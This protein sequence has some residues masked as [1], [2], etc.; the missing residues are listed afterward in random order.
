[1][2]EFHDEQGLER[3][4][5]PKLTAAKVKDPNAA[6]TKQM[7][8]KHM[9]L[10]SCVAPPQPKNAFDVFMQDDGGQVPFLMES[11]RLQAAGKCARRQ[12][13]SDSTCKLRQRLRKKRVFAKLLKKLPRTPRTPPHTE[14]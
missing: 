2:Q 7:K 13:R 3:G 4:A 1:L 10:A 11:V 12:R 5:R 14:S 8:G 6:K 9:Y